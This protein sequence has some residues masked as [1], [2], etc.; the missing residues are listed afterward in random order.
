MEVK[1]VLKGCK[2]GNQIAQSVLFNTHYKHMYNLSMRILA[3][4][5]DVEDVLIISFTKVFENIKKFEYRGDHSL[6][7]WIKTIIINESIR[8][9]KKRDKIK[10]DDNLP[11]LEIS[12]E[13]DSDLSDVDI[14]QIY[15]IIE[16]MPTGYRIVFNLFA[17][18]GYSHKEISDLLQITVST[19]KSQLRKGRMNIIKKIN[20]IKN[21]GKA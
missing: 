11:D 7:I 16:T 15:S 5:N 21:N 20:K 2:S 4:H 1:E 6:V 19:S 14:E 8:F 18:E 13:F 12:E 3:N 9:V 17:I 10:Y